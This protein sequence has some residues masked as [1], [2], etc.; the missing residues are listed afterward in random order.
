MNFLD[1]SFIIAIFLSIILGI[2]KG[3]LRELIGLIFLFLAVYCSITYHAQVAGAIFSSIE[4]TD[5]SF[6]LAFLVVFFGLLI[7]GS[8]MGY[9][10]KKV[11]IMGPLKSVDRIMGAFF[12]LL[13]GI[14]ISCVIL[15]GLIVF[16]INDQ[17]VSGSFLAPYA[18]KPILLIAS[19]LPESMGRH[20]KKTT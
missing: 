14:V 13:R 16:P 18:G 15:M 1:I 3:F 6:F 19:L 12:G 5:V 9:T 20:F 10:L 2:V 17:W 8:L 4:D 11:F 7:L